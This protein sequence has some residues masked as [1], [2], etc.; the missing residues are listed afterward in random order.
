MAGLSG[1]HPNTTHMGLQK[2]LDQEWDFVQ[3][4]IPDIGTAFQNVQDEL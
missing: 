3:R 1:N 2:S 4:V